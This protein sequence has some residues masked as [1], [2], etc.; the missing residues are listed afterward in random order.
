MPE[1]MKRK[2]KKSII[3]QINSNGRSI[4]F[5][6]LCTV[7]SGI[8]AVISGIVGAIQ[9]HQIFGGDAQTAW[10]ITVVALTA[11]FV[12]LV[13]LSF[14]A[15]I[16][17][18]WKRATRIALIFSGI[19]LITL[20]SYKLFTQQM[21]KQANQ[22]KVIVVIAQFDGPEATY[23]LRNQIL[24]QLSTSL[25]GDQDIKIISINE[26]VTIAQGSDYARQLGK[27]YQAD[28]VFWGWYRSTENPSLTLHIENL[29][30]SKFAVLQQ[31]EIYKPQASIADLQSF[32]LQQKIGYQTSALISFLS[33]LLL[34]NSNKYDIA[35]TRFQ[36]ALSQPDWSNEML[37]QGDVYFYFANAYLDTGK[38]KDAISNYDK[39][40]QINPQFAD[41]YSSRGNAYAKQDQYTLAIADYNYA[42]QINPKYAN[43]YFNRGDAYVNQG[44][45]VKGIEDYSEA[46]QLN[47]QDEGAYFGRGVA[48]FDQ[49]RY[50][51]AIEDYTQAIQI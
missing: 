44:L 26:T 43:A 9:L 47:P 8:S 51:Q 21:V 28:L 19:I 27:Q 4:L 1:K 41:A 3:R 10:N 25:Q 20:W 29:S 23:G 36:Q 34:Y 35:I 31:S 7:I 33:G 46:I 16:S 45:Y 22:N 17:K 39:A 24:E 12:F 5:I 49:Q 37:N 40:I 30:P 32:S 48:Y 14:F 13:W 18:P 50:S 6:S 42:I 2:D 11:C 15:K 38:Y